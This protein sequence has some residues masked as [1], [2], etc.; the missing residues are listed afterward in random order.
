ME[1]AC[2]TQEYAHSTQEHTHSTHECGD[3]SRESSRSPK[4]FTRICITQDFRG[5]INLL[6][7]GGGKNSSIDK[8][9]MGFR[10]YQ[11]VWWSPWEF[12]K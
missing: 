1:R 7:R 8:Q 12:K 11:S 9:N 2:S 5:N 3:L 6:T 4:K 10:R